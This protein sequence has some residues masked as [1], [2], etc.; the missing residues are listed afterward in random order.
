MRLIS[1]SVK[2]QSDKKLEDYVDTIENK[3]HPNWT[4]KENKMQPKHGK[5][6]IAP[7]N[8]GS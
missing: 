5:D 6:N 3:T 4:K 8:G 1:D 2:K 7:L